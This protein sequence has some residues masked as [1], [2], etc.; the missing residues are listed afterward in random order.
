MSDDLKRAWDEADG[1]RGVVRDICGAIDPGGR[2]TAS[3]VE[4]K[5]EEMRREVDEAHKALDV[6]IGRGDKVT[7]HVFTLAERVGFVLSGLR[8]ETR[9]ADDA[10]DKADRQARE[11]ERLSL[12]EAACVREAL[13]Q[14]GTA[15]A[16]RD[17][18]KAQASANAHGCEEQKAFREAAE[19]ERDAAQA[20]VER[21]KADLL[22][23]GTLKS[24]EVAPVIER[25]REAFGADVPQAPS[26]QRTLTFERAI[27][28]GEKVHGLYPSEAAA[29]LLAEF[30]E[31]AKVEPPVRHARHDRHC[32]IHDG[33]GC[34]REPGCE[35]ER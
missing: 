4:Q 2:V 22:L 10:E 34:S 11:I 21:L 6:E 20:E 27:Q 5:A 19:T 17:E 31:P 12:S 1:L 16:E 9:R 13:E 32:L 28:I 26:G 3:N 7:G 15:R 24:E 29:V 33:V 25:F 35:V 18:W 30:G 14:V 8:E 23:L